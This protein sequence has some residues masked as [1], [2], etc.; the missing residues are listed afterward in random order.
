M[1]GALTTTRLH[2]VPLY[3]TGLAA[4][5]PFHDHHRSFLLNLGFAAWV[6]AITHLGSERKIFMNFWP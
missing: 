2:P 1:L 5:A 6:T 4:L 3:L